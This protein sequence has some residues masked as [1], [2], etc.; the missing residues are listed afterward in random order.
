[1]LQIC[2]VTHF[3]Y[4]ALAGGQ[5]GHIGGVERQCSLMSKWLVSRGYRVSMITWDEGQEDG[6]EIDGVLVFKMCRENAGI[7]GLRFFW[8]M[9]PSHLCW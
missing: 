7:K 5:I 4:G 6:K 1:M 8:P 3:A 2:F 9:Y